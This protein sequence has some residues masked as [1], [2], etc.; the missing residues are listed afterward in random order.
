M[1]DMFRAVYYARVSTE[2]ELQLNA[3]R[4]Q[5]EV[6]EEY[7]KNKE[8][9]IFVRG[10][11]DE[12]KTATTV[13]S[14][15]E[16]RQLISDMSKDMFDVVVIIRVDRGWRNDRDWALF[17]TELILTKIKLYT[18]SNHSFY[19]FRDSGSWLQAGIEAKFAELF[20][21]QQ[22]I[23]MTDAFALGKKKG[24]TYGNSRIWGYDYIDGKF[25]IN[26]KE[27]ELVQ[28]VFRRYIEGAGFRTISKELFEQ[29][30][31]CLG[32]EGNMFPLTTLKR[33]IK[34]PK[35][36]GTLVTNKTH[37]DFFEKKQY[38][39]PESEWMVF[40]DK[41]P[42][43]ID[44]WTFQRANEIL[45]SKRKF[46]Q[47][48]SKVFGFYQGPHSL[49]RKIWCAKCGKPYYFNK[50][51]KKG[52]RS[53]WY[54][55]T[56]KCWGTNKEKYGCDNI[57]IPAVEMDSMVKHAIFKLWEDKEKT[58]SSVLHTI[59]RSMERASK[60]SQHDISKKHARLD[61]LNEVKRSM[62]QL[63]YRGL[64]SEE[65]YLADLQRTDNEIREIE[66]RISETA[67]PQHKTLSERLVSIEEYLSHSIDSIDCVTDDMIKNLVNRVIID[68][69]I[70]ILL[71]QQS[72]ITSEWQMPKK[73][74]LAQVQNETPAQLKELNT[75]YPC[76]TNPVRW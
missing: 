18:V 59:Q 10:Y 46:N 19:D 31:Y 14:R 27:S 51:T 55:S 2:A 1:N 66:S 37:F 45:E 56:Y 74:E 63:L 7:I 33:M 57:K 52:Q 24:K 23:K 41:I 38:I 16:Y 54:C 9:W 60:S 4:N 53:S 12:G 43:I 73:K 50:S 71:I 36:K 44:K 64:I 48:K 3:L 17:E 72:T 70:I 69:N 67:I 6:L 21:R 25:V 65:D 47:D 34:N 28:Y 22:S 39:L 11:V 35:Y 26:E 20:S 13:K 40:E 42:A 29:G 68:D 62:R 30:R 61:E 49:S 15:H 76:V 32:T 8:D 75:I 5:I 58:K